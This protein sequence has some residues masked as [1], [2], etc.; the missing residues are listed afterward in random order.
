MRQVLRQQLA[1]RWLQQRIHRSAQ[2]DVMAIKGADLALP[3]VNDG[4]QPIDPVGRLHDDGMRRVDVA[5]LLG[6]V[7]VCGVHRS[8]GGGVSNTVVDV[9]SVTIAVSALE[10][11]HT[12]GWVAAYNWKSL[13]SI[14]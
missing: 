8:P 5:K 4:T 13:I 6:D 3:F 2:F 14:A 11:N 12:V 7:Y 1:G 9:I 10:F